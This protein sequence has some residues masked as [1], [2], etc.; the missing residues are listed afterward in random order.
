MR[1]RLL[2]AAGSMEGRITSMSDDFYGNPETGLNEHRT[3]RAMRDFLR[4]SGFE[5]EEGVAGLPTAFRARLGS[6]S[7]VVALLAEMDALEGMGHA[8]GHNIGGMASVGAASALARSGVLDNLRGTVLVLGTP[9]EELGKGKTRMVAEG[10][11]TGVDA[12]MMVHPS[13][14]RT[15]EKGFIGVYRYDFV[16]HGRPSHASAYPEE[17][18]NALDAVIQTFNSVNALRQQMPEG[19][20][21]HGIITDGGTA[22]NIIPERAAASF[23]VRAPEM[24]MLDNLRDRV[25]RCASAAAAATGCTLEAT[26]VGEMNAPMKVNLVLAEAYRGVLAGL[27]LAEDERPPHKGLGSS[28]IGNV[29]QVVPTIHPHVPVRRGLHIHT[30]EFAE[31]TV[32]PEGHRALMEGVKCLGL[33]VLE[34]LS[35]PKLV[36]EAKK[37]FSKDP[38]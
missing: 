24:A 31:A 20:R 5:V 14:K 2:E 35:N 27:G 37:F 25:V 7:P 8:C 30:P 21:V 9:A 10:V 6:S 32:T 19:A 1:K 12:A 22:P 13:S 28:D 34:L 26:Q 15:V 29:S 4:E 18:I 3:S 23:Y 16:F 33:M 17:G 11:F 36:E 38:Q